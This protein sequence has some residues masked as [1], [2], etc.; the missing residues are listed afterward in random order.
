[1]TP[2]GPIHVPRFPRH[3]TPSTIIPPPSTIIPNLPNHHSKTSYPSFRRKPESSV[4]ICTN[5]N[6]TQQPQIPAK[7]RNDGKFDPTP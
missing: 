3:T 4:A 2:H 7:S 5:G 1:M 6:S